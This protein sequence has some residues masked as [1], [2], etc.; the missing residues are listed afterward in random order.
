[1]TVS[2]GNFLS[3]SNACKIV[4]RSTIVFLTP[5]YFHD[6]C[7]S[8]KELGTIAPPSGSP[9]AYML[10]KK[11]QL[12]VSMRQR[13]MAMREAGPPSERHSGDESQS[14]TSSRLKEGSN[15]ARNLRRAQ[16]NEAIVQDLCNVVADLFIA[17]SKL[18]KPFQYGVVPVEADDE[19]SDDVKER[20]VHPTAK[21][22]EV[23]RQQVVQTVHQFVAALPTRYAL[24]A[25]TPSEVLLHMRI[26]AAARA[27]KY[28]VVVH[29]HTV[30]D[31]QLTSS[32]PA[33]T[34]SKNL[35]Q[36]RL[37]TICCNDANGLLEYISKLLATGGS[38]V[39][40]AD[41]ML[42]T[43]GIVLVSSF[44]G[45][46]LCSFNGVVL[47]DVYLVIFVGSLLG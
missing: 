8:S 45:S 17:E 43:D 11:E 6:R 22:Q 41:V 5:P 19:K 31:Q 29:I 14:S 13:L 44:R 7:M 38:R 24:S 12:E 35:K 15:Q 42:S 46:C 27:D 2:E 18:L 30:S 20:T 26:M 25:D 40:D 39:V 36:L 23:L 4:C 10:Y 47:T 16:H 1:M 37:V 21:S 34:T 33:A 32:F 3:A 28:K 9:Y